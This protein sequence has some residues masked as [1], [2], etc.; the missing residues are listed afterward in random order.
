MTDVLKSL[1]TTVRHGK[2]RHGDTEK[3][4]VGHGKARHGN[5]TRKSKR[6]P[7]SIM[8]FMTF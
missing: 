3:P 7:V 4:T 5:G 2:A 6:F 8:T 1:P